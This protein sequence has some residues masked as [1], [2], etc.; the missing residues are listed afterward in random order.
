MEPASFVLEA[1]GHIESD[2][3]DKFGVPR[4]PGLAPAARAR[5]VLHGDYA[6]PLAVRGLDTCSHVWLT[7]IFHHSPERWTPLVRPPRLGGNAKLGVFA[8]RSTHR[9]NRLGLSLAT[10][11]AIDTRHGVA[12]E[13][14]GCDLVDGTPVLDIKPYLPWAEALPNAQAGIA[15]DAPPR[16]AVRFCQDAV[17]AI[18]QRSDSVSLRALIEQVLAQDPRPAYH[19]D[20]GDAERIYGVRLRDVDVRFRVEQA[21][22]PT[23]MHVIELVTLG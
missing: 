16:Y 14:H 4:Q 2:F 11:G 22:E 6:D 13:L 7:F 21:G 15:P 18:E 9:P 5:L 8:T 17:D 23:W 20:K 1:I 3:R 10:L 19:R 12:L